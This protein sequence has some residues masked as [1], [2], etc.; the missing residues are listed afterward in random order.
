MHIHVSQIHVIRLLVV[1]CTES[2]KT[3]FTEISL[4]GI[5]SLDNHIDTHIKLFIVN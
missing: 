5:N 4:N 3:F 2:G 1:L